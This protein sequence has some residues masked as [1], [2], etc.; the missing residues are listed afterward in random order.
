M[1]LHER[2]VAIITLLRDIGPMSRRELAHLMRIDV[3]LVYASMRLLKENGKLRIVRWDR[4]VGK[5]PFTPIY[6]EGGGVDVERP[7]GW[8]R[9]DISRRYYQRNAAVI[10]LRRYPNYHKSFGIWSGLMK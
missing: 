2:R 5:G 4:S 3:Q 1:T 6:A 8:T 9:N 7:K 10:S